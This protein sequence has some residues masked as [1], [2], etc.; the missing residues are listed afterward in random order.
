M[1]D[2]A[3]R[4]YV[5]TYQRSTDRN[6]TP[7]EVESLE[8]LFT[9]LGP[10]EA[11][12]T[13]EN[14]PGKRC[15]HKDGLA[16][17]PGYIPAGKTRLAGNVES[18]SVAVFDLDHLT[19]AQLEDVAAHVEG[20]ECI[21]HSSHTHKP[22]DNQA[23]RLAFPLKRAV[24][25][26]EW[27]SLW[28]AIVAKYELP[29]D[30]KAKDPCRIYFLMR[31]PKGAEFIHARGEGKLL[32]P[33]ELLL[34]HIMRSKAKAA[35]RQTVEMPEPEP[36]ETDIGKLRA[37]LR[38]YAPDD[39]FSGEKRELIRRVVKGEPLADKPGGT[40][41]DFGEVKLYG[42]DDAV[43]KAG[44]IVGWQLPLGTPTEVAVE[45]MHASI[46]GIPVYDDDK[47][48]ECFDGWMAKAAHKF[49]DS[50]K[51]KYEKLAEHNQMREIIHQ[52]F[53]K[54]TSPQPASAELPANSSPPPAAPPSVGDD[55]EEP[56]VGTEEEDPHAWRQRMIHKVSGKDGV[57]LVEQ[58]GYNAGLILQEHPEWKGR[59]RFNEVTKDVECEGGP[60][61]KVERDADML[62]AVENWL[63]RYEDMKLHT[64]VVCAQMLF[65]ARKRRYDPVTD[66]L[67]G[68]IWDGFQRL[69]TFFEMYCGAGLK[70]DSHDVTEYI[71]KAGVKWMI[72]A[73]ARGLRPGCKVDSV[74]VLE[75]PQG[76]GKTTMLETLGGE[77]YVKSE[78]VLTDKDSKMLVGRA[79]IVELAELASVRNT[80][81][82]AQK[83]F[84]SAR[85]DMFRPPYGRKVETFP[86]RCVFAGTTNETAYLRDETGNRRFWPIPCGQFNIAAI[87]R[88]RDQLW[89]EAVARFKAGE[90]WYFNATEA[91][92][93]EEVANRRLRG[94]QFADAVWDWWL[95]MEPSARPR[96]FTITDVAVDALDIPKWKVE[97]AQT[98]IGRALKKMEFIRKRVSE[99]NVR[100]WVY[101]ATDKHLELP[102]KALNRRG[103]LKLVASS[104]AIN[105]PA[106]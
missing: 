86:R 72:G 87:R 2:Q 42:R 94:T 12:C 45:I 81:T 1:V 34:S 54:K 41:V 97:D 60:L 55:P 51:K 47:P 6:S 78:N 67:N 14:C 28:H 29:A 35:E 9:L 39:D 3:W 46:A 73:V 48:E 21:L 13:A 23:L 38:Q 95:R 40:E 102:K 37:Y 76:V 106:E 88:D 36:G 80:E 4:G 11:P 89:A 71:R 22:P 57:L 8:D 26:K 96:Q 18:L 64:N 99:N 103:V 92:L 43:F 25:R 10:E 68:I 93:A 58:V 33:D 24:T 91:A 77:W 85:E 90:A 62:T 15:P 105:G 82:E 74:I 49:E 7:F 27:T 83:A 16:W 63:Q 101:E 31:H 75:G 66:Y 98:A 69:D 19:Q 53:G 84:F 79:W 20:V 44:T 59:L 52:R 5:S 17:S 56:A 70:D 30:P 61:S 65:T 100:T 104:E 32:D 50:Q